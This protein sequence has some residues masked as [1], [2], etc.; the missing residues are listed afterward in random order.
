M[1]HT[2]QCMC[3]YTADELGLV[4]YIHSFFAP[5]TENPRPV[6]QQDKVFK[7]NLN[8]IYWKIPVAKWA[9]FLRKNVVAW[10]LTRFAAIGNVAT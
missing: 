9:L 5:E 8:K 7:V 2:L 3:W 4:F 10:V 1:T 6:P